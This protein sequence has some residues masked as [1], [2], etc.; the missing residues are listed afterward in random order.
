MDDGPA[1]IIDPCRYAGAA[2]AHTRAVLA[3]DR[4]NA[5][6]TPGAPVATRNCLN[7]LI[8]NASAIPRSPYCP[9]PLVATKAES[10]ACP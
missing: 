2:G 5:V 7:C 10:T 1:R 3:E 6:V 8:C 9:R 4:V